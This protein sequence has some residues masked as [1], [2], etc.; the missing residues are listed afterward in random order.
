MNVVYFDQQTG[1]LQA[2]CWL[3]PS[4]WCLTPFSITKAKKEEKL[5]K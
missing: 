3:K 5:Q 1:A 2:L 4:F